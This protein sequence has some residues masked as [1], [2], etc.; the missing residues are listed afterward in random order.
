MSNTPNVRMQKP[1][2]L[3]GVS[4]Q[5]GAFTDGV[6]KEM[7]AIS[8]RPIIFPLS[9]PTSRAE[10]TARQAYEWTDGK[11][12]FAS[13]SP[14]DPEEVNGEMCYPSQCNNMVREKD[15]VLV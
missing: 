11:A 15:P 1:T 10:C 7:C 5:R 12:I 4:T 9:N 3:V 14:F 8:E 6:I 13:G 2:V